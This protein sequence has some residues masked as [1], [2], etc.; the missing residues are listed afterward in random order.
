MAARLHLGGYD[1]G[2][3]DAKADAPPPLKASG[4]AGGT[5]RAG[6]RGGR[7]DH[8]KMHRDYSPP[9]PLKTPEGLTT[10]LGTRTMGTGT[11]GVFNIVAVALSLIAVPGTILCFIVDMIRSFGGGDAD[12]AWT[13]GFSKIFMMS[14]REFYDKLRAHLVATGE[15]EKGASRFRRVNQEKYYT[16]LYTKFSDDPSA[17]RTQVAKNTERD[18]E[19]FR[20]LNGNVDPA[21]V[22]QYADCAA[23]AAYLMTKIEDLERQVQNLKYENEIAQAAISQAQ[24]TSHAVV[25]RAKAMG[26]YQSDIGHAFGDPVPEATPR[27]VSRAD[28]LRLVDDPTFDAPDGVRVSSISDDTSVYSVEPVHSVDSLAAARAALS[29]AREARGETV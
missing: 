2:E 24:T 22:E 14:P 28:Q 7:R 5:H 8:S 17:V 9:R 10:I 6:R 3:E 19:T 4:G 11:R 20:A 25:E 13:S 27:M 15:L 26:R 1:S 18:G 16:D 12:E 29:A 21:I 23:T